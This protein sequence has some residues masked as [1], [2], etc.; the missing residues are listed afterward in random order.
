MV[1]DQATTCPHCGFRLSH[2]HD[3]KQEAY[4]KNSV[5]SQSNSSHVENIKNRERNMMP[6][7]HSTSSIILIVLSVLSCTFIPIL[8]GIIALVTDSTAKNLYMVGNLDQAQL[9]S[10]EAGKWLRIGWIVLLV[11]LGLG[12]LSI[13]LFGVSFFA[14]IPLIAGILSEI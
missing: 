2:Q 10:N 6:I 12:F 1:S 9:Q 8:F 3:Y 4:T 13:L 14:G 5:L 7:S 11:I